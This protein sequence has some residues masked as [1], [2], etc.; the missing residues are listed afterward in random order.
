VKLVTCTERKAQR[1]RSV[2][3]KCEDEYFY[4]KE[5]RQLPNEELLK[6]YS[7]QNNNWVIE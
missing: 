4:L 7:T 6:E 5:K 1:E 2:K 3:T